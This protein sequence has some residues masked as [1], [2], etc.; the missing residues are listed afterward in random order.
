[1]GLQNDL[2]QIRL[3]SGIDS[4]LTPTLEGV[5]KAEYRQLQTDYRDD[6]SYRSFRNSRVVIEKT[7]QSMS[8][9]IGYDNFDFSDDTEINKKL[10]HDFWITFFTRNYFKALNYETVDEWASI[11]YAKL[12]EL[13]PL[14]NTLIKKR[15][16]DI[17]ITH[18]TQTAGDMM[19]NNSSDSTSGT[20]S[21]ND[22]NG[23]SN[24]KGSSKATHDNAFTDT[25]QNQLAIGA[26][27]PGY[28]TTLTGDETS[29]TTTNDRT[30]EAHATGETNSNGHVA[31]N[32][33]SNTSGKASGRDLDVFV[34]TTNWVNSKYGVWLDIFDRLDDSG[35]FSRV[36]PTSN[37][38]KTQT[39]APRTYPGYRWFY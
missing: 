29:N 18:D 26:N 6:L 30:E 36:M 20:T 31:G 19:G 21:K 7:W 24:D 22:N 15:L 25:P 34:M 35:L 39:Q 16:T 11:L 3:S 32:T 37:A 9:Y 13:M 5:L 4:R 8:D 1:M 10:V 14:Y 38:M 12:S 2:D 33:S 28:A 23:K 17:W 27:N